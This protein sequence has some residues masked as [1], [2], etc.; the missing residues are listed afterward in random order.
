VKILLLA[1]A[2]FVYVFLLAPFLVVALASL[3][4]SQAFFY[5]FPPRH[6]SLAW[7]A[8][9]PA[10][11]FHAFGV[12]LLIGA[13]T[14]AVATSVGTM[15]AF[16]LVRGGLRRRATLEAFFRLP[17][18]VPFVVTG[19]VFLQFYY[20][21]VDVAG[22]NLAGR[23]PGLILA[24]VFVTIPYVVG[25]VSSVLLRM[26]RR[27]EEAAAVLGASPWSTFRRVTLP[28][29]RPGIVAG[30]LYAFI[31]SFGDVPIAVFLSGS[32]ATTLPVEIFQSLQFDF[33][34][35]VLALSTLVVLLS[36]ALIVI[37]QRVVGLEIVLRTG[38]R[39]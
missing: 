17:L 34:P 2:V 32:G 22:V 35:A 11:Y 23:L 15:A 27:L 5:N 13:V 24:H 38:G 19:V 37:M 6:L 31:I 25:T 10:K 33:N 4:G 14:A 36:V 8:Q 39:A 28:I 26:N 7:Y 12:S 18:Q 16:G 30:A 3:D 1:V 20:H 29:I 9:I 21:M